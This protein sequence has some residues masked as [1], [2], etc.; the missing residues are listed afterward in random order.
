MASNRV[1]LS[2]CPSLFKKGHGGCRVQ[3]VY[4]FFK[5]DYTAPP[6]QVQRFPGGDW[7]SESFRDFDKSV[8]LLSF[9]KWLMTG[10]AN[11]TRNVYPKS[12]SGSVETLSAPAQWTNVWLKQALNFSYSVCSCWLISFFFLIGLLTSDLFDLFLP[13]LITYFCF[14][15]TWNDWIHYK[16]VIGNTAVAP[17]FNFVADFCLSPLLE[18]FSL[19]LSL[20]WEWTCLGVFLCSFIGV[21]LLNN[22]SGLMW[23]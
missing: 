10:E 7:V 5:A 23:E 16:V 12:L 4:I 3:R 19:H 6:Q 8:L 13:L 14:G 21:T 18:I 15:L 17:I 20:E 9:K 22:W 2:T 11:Q 1:T